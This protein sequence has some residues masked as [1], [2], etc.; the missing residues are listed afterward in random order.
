MQL[1]ILLAPMAG[2]CPASLSIAVANAGGMGA[3]GALVSKPAAIRAWVEEFR[4]AS[5]GPF[6]LNTWIPDPTLERDPEAE[7]R[8]RKFLAAWGPEVAASAGDA[9]PPDA[10]EQY[11]AFLALKPTAVSSIMGLYPPDYVAQLKQ[12]GIA[13]FAT[14]TTLSEAQRAQDAGS[15]AVIAQGAEAGWSSGRRRASDAGVVRSISR[16]GKTHLGWRSCPPDLGRS[17]AFDLAFCD[18]P[19]GISRR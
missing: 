19:P 13:W 8:V 10:L 16:D 17:A 3:M 18:H 1:P 5:H 14:A 6:Q 7:A 9:K 4:S 2:A 12:N 15:D 11:E